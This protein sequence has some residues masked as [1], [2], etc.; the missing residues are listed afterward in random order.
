MTTHSGF[1]NS[2]SSL[3]LENKFTVSF[4]YETVLCIYLSFMAVYH[5]TH[6]FFCLGNPTCSHSESLNYLF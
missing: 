6:F 2:C 1:V 5:L 3:M 4:G